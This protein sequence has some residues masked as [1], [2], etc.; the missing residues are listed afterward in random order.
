MEVKEKRAER[1]EEKIKRNDAKHK[2]INERN[3][4][5]VVEK[6]EN[7]V[8]NLKKGDADKYLF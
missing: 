8:K 2:K 5:K 1:K 3:I 4:V 7:H 6:R